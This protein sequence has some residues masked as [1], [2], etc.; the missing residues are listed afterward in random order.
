VG[1]SAFSY[2][3]N[4]DGVAR[5]RHFRQT[6]YLCLSGLATAADNGRLTT[7]ADVGRRLAA[8]TDCGW[9]TTTPND[10]TGLTATA[11]D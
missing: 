2:L 3:S 9:L 10:H 11:M 4:A 1:A 7:A 5:R 6:D 8:T